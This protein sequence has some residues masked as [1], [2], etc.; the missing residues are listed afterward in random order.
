MGLLFSG[1]SWITLSKR[2]THTF[3]YLDDITVAAVNPADHEKNVEAFF[4]VMKRPSL[5][6]NHAKS[7]ISTLSINV[8][9]YLVRDGEIRPDPRDYVHSN[10]FFCQQMS[11]HYVELWD[12][13]I[14]MLNGYQNFHLKSNP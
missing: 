6:L 8:L 1:V 14:T 5:T 7:V 3:P 13:L 9:G 2:E 4:D 10:N 12:Y 11:S